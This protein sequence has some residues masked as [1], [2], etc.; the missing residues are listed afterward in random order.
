MTLGRVLSG[1]GV[2]LLVLFIFL[3]M[4]FQARNFLQ[5]P[6][7]SL[8]GEYYPVQL[9]EVLTI[10]GNAQNIV[11]LTLN[12]REISTDAE[13]WFSETIQ[14]EKGYAIYT[15][16]AEDRYGRSTTV[17]RGYVYNPFAASK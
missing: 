15:L 3:Y 8:R 7:V 12:G 17:E 16:Y 11:R 2:A 14:L 1:V 4:Q 10:A 5:G 6:E 9:S 13:G